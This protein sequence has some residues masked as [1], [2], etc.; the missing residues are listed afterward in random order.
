MQVLKQKLCS[1]TLAPAPPIP[2]H[3]KNNTTTNKKTSCNRCSRSL[4]CKSLNHFAHLQPGSCKLCL[5][6]SQLHFR[7]LQGISL[8]V[9]PA[10]SSCNDGTCMTYASPRGSCQSGDRGRH[11]LGIWTLGESNAHGH[12]HRQEQ[13]VTR[14][15]ICIVIHQKILSV[16][17]FFCSCFNMSLIIINSLQSGTRILIWWK[18][19]QTAVLSKYKK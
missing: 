14:T 5:R 4:K 17:S 11:R 19:W 18:H 6:H 1:A 10:L 15:W 16:H 7:W 2:Q 9:G 8:L 3:S 13:E 12:S